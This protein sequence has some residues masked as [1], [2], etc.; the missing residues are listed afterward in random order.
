MML[1]GQG[2]DRHREGK[3]CIGQSRSMANALQ[4]LQAD[5]STCSG[6]NAL[7]SS[8]G[9]RVAQAIGGQHHGRY[10]LTQGC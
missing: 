2:G 4:M 6:H 3:A 7:Q 10:K 1:L 8:V 9:T 5:A